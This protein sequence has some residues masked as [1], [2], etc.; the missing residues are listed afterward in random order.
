ME[1]KQIVIYPNDILS[2]PTASVFAFTDIRNNILVNNS[3][4]TGTATGNHFNIMYFI[5]KYNSK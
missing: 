3:T 1:T 2:T 5:M 4:N